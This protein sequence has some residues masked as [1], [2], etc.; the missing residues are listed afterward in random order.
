MSFSELKL[1]TKKSKTSFCLYRN[2]LNTLSHIHS[3]TRCWQRYYREKQ[4]KFFS[5]TNCSVHFKRTVLYGGVQVLYTLKHFISVVKAKGKLYG[6]S[7][8]YDGTFST[9]SGIARMKCGYGTMWW[10][11]GTVYR[12]HWRNDVYDGKGRLVEGK[13]WLRLG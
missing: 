12:G 3:R 1:A 5:K 6:K 11:D 10:N 7:G 4:F 8:I 9:T 2:I 13:R